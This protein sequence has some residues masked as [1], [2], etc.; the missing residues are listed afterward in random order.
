MNQEPQNTNFQGYQPQ[1]IQ[2]NN[3]NT[4]QNLR[5]NVNPDVLQQ[6]VQSANQNAQ[7]QPVQA[8]Q[9]VPQQQPPVAPVQNVSNQQ[10]SAPPSGSPY[11]SG[12]TYAPSANQTNSFALSEYSKIGGALL[13]FIIMQAIYVFFMLAGFPDALENF[14]YSIANLSSGIAGYSVS[15][16]LEASA[17]FIAIATL[18]AYSIIIITSLVQLITR[19]VSFLRFFQIAGIIAAV[20]NFVVFVLKEIININYMYSISE[21]LYSSSAVGDHWALVML[22]LLWTIFWT[23]YFVRAVRIRTFMSPQNPYSLEQGVPYIDRALFGKGMK[24]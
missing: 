19:N 5:Q 6:P 9:T 1:N 18:I 13:A 17:N 22:A 10:P 16:I 15:Y 12:N 7:G 20:G 24:G 11:Y 3:Q 21:T 23:L 4:Q 14:L 8:T 2:Y